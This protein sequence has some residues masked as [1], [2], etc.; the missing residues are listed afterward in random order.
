M[1]RPAYSRSASGFCDAG[2][3]EIHDGSIDEACYLIA[4]DVTTSDAQGS[5]ERFAGGALPFEF[6]ITTV[7][8][9]AILA[10]E[11]RSCQ[12]NQP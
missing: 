7:V 3:R 10:I 1:D 8:Q 6:C 4:G 12:C 2:T 5:S 11:G 9:S